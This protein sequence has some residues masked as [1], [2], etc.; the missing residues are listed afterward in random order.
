MNK[1]LLE[2]ETLKKIAKGLKKIR[3]DKNF[4]LRYGNQLY[5][6]LKSNVY[7][8]SDK[9]MHFITN[10]LDK[11]NICFKEYLITQEELKELVAISTDNNIKELV[12]VLII[13]VN[14]L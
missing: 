1:K 2:N 9:F 7:N 14:T 3:E 5:V 13:L 4:N 12:D 10:L 6:D 11:Y 8:R